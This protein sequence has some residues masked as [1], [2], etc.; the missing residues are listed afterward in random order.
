MTDKKSSGMRF[1]PIITKD[2]EASGGMRLPPVI[3]ADPPISPPP[4]DPIKPGPGQIPAVR[5]SSGGMHHE[6]II[7]RK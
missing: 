1:D 3:T 5:P 2:G 6:P 4:V 7:T